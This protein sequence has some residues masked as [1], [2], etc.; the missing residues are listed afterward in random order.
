LPMIRLNLRSG[1]SASRYVTV[2]YSG[3][4]NLLS[5]DAIVVAASLTDQVLRG[6]FR[7]TV[8]DPTVSPGTLLRPSL[9]PSIQSIDS[10]Q[11]ASVVSDGRSTDSNESGSLRA[12]RISTE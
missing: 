9:I 6:P 3:T 1:G 8:D 10:K 5:Y 4:R 12:A 2:A 11:A 7:A